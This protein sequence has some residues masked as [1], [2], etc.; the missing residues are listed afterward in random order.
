MQGRRFNLWFVLLVLLGLG[1]MVNGVWMLLDSAGWFSRIAA[2]VVP[3][4]THLVRD[5][6]AAYFATGVGLVWAA[7]Q[8]AWRIPLVGLSLIFH[9]LHALGHVRETFSGEL[10]PHHWIEDLPGI[11]LPTLLMVFM[12]VVFYRR[13]ALA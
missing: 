7:F 9:G 13:R 12:L 11:Y 2:D 6:G 10:G 8:A 1:S 3:Y 5:V 4:N